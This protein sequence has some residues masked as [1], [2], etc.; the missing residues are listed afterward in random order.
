M[1]ETFVK[2]MQVRR[3]V[4][5]EAHEDR[6]EAGKTDFDLPFQSSSTESAWGTVWA[7]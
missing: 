7:S 6:A 4:L 3:E 2:G 5:G 1:T